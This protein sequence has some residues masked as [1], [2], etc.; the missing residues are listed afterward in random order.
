MKKPDNIVYNKNEYD[1]YKKNYPTSFNSKSFELEEIK[2]LN[3]ISK[4]YFKTKYLEIENDYKNFLEEYRWNDLINKS[5]FNFNPLIGKEYYL[6][7]NNN[8]STFL[9]L[10]NPKEWKKPCIGVFK[11][12]SNNIWKKIK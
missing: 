3:P 10:I 6:Y 1:A 4:N 11:L 5:K 7:S 2:D 12:D 8:N 9:S